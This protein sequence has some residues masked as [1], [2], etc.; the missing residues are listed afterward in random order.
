M[1]AVNESARED[2]LAIM[3]TPMCSSRQALF[4]HSLFDP[5]SI[6]SQLSYP[7]YGS[8]LPACTCLRVN[9]HD[10]STFKHGTR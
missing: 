3:L 5:P 8:H 6:S 4:V 2:M 7:R 10:T 1:H 9:L